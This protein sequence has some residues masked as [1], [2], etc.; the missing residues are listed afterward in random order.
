VNH[1]VN[2]VGHVLLHEWRTSDTPY[3]K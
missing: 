2:T 1:I 3:R